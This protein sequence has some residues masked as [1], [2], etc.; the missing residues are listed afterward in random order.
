[1]VLDLTIEQDIFAKQLGQE[2]VSG[3]LTPVDAV[4]KLFGER[5][6]NCIRV[7]L[8]DL[9]T[10][11]PRSVVNPG[12][13]VNRFEN[14]SVLS[15]EGYSTWYPEV[16]FSTRKGVSFQVTD[17]NANGFD[18]GD[19]VY[20][21]GVRRSFA[22][23]QQILK[24][25]VNHILRFNHVQFSAQLFQKVIRFIDSFGSLEQPYIA[26]L[27]VGIR[28]FVDDRIV[29][30]RAVA[31][32]HVVTGER[33]FCSCHAEVHADMVSDAKSR[34]SSFIP[35][36]WP[37]NVIKVLDHGIYLR[38]LCHF[39]VIEQ[40]GGDAHLDWYGNQIR[41]QYG[42][43][44]DFL[45]RGK[46][47]DL[48]TAKAEARRRLSISR[49]I[50]EDELYRLMSKL[51][52]TKI[53]Q[54]EASPSWLGRQRLDVFLPELGLAVEHQGE[55]HYR[56]IALFGGKDGFE[57]TRDRD[58][59]KRELCVANEITVVDIRFD[60]SLTLSSLRHRLRKWLR[61]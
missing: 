56:P 12:Y 54:R 16:K 46:H 45:V 42:P 33:R 31:F 57:K 40:H 36:S 55:Q 60:Q 48:T 23:R 1:M 44:V 15:R 26:N 50:R 14:L 20:G 41:D 9:L 2:I 29:G 58:I 8:E 17:V 34:A 13:Y 39:C 7:A 43:Y 24:T 37:Q 32:D 38:D 59:R 47:M 5:M 53:I 10:K 52:P 51:F 22:Y 30:F 4:E 61:D 27:T 18:L 19:L 35:D 3:C 11:S 49:W 6:E 28:N 25:Q 21:G